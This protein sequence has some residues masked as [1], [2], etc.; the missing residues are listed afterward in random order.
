MV[1]KKIQP[2]WEKERQRLKHREEMGNKMGNDWGHTSSCSK[3]ISNR[4]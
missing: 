4:I 2:K 1:K 3:N